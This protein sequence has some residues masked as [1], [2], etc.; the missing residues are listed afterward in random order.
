MKTL[1]IS[2]TAIAFAY[3]AAA[4]LFLARRKLGYSHLKH[5]ISE[6]GEI[7]AP[8]QSFVAF[9]LFLPIGLVLLVIAFITQ[10]ASPQ[11]ATLALCIAIGYLTTAFFPC[12]PGSP[13]SGSARQAMHNLGGGIEYIGGGLALLALAK[14]LGQTF[15]FTGYLVLGCTLALSIIP[16]TTIRGMIQRIAETSLF[17][18]LAFA[19]WYGER[20]V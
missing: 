9:G 12:D 17:F 10:S 13:I 14:Q 8:D 15:Q 3:L 2:L 20:V 18:S 1:A 4:L 5:T 16:S 19:L 11:S 7:D 6:I